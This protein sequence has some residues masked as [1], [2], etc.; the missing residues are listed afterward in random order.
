VVRYP[1]R[2]NPETNEAE[3]AKTYTVNGYLGARK[4]WIIMRLLAAENPL[5]R[6]SESVELFLKSANTRP[7]TNPSVKE[8]TN[9]KGKMTR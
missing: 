1:L 8:T 9:E 7:A 5:A 4:S 6:Y 3:Y 2:S